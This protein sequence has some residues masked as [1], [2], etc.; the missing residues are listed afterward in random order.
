ME[1]YIRELCKGKSKDFL[2]GFEAG[3]WAFAHWKDGIQYVGTT[4]GLF[5]AV[6]QAIYKIKNNIPPT[7]KSEE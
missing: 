5:S 6:Q 1:D 4:G 2:E 7:P 3:A